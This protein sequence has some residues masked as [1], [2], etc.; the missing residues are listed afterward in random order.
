PDGR[1]TLEGVREGS[2]TLYVH[3]AGWLFPPTSVTVVGRQVSEVVVREIVGGD[4]EIVVR[5]TDGN[6][7]PFAEL[8][9][10]RADGQVWHDVDDAGVQRLDPYVDGRGRRLLTHLPPGTLRV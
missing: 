7:V 5:D 6:P 3:E 10:G 9:V 8:D 4:V 2:A 1:A